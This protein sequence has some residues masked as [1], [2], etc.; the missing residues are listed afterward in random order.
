MAEGKVD[1]ITTK[2][3]EIASRYTRTQKTIY[4]FKRLLIFVAVFVLSYYAAGESFLLAL[5][6]KQ[7]AKASLGV[8][9]A[10][11]F[12]KF[13]FPK[14]ALQHELIEEQNLAVAVVAAAIILGVCLA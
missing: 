1:R 11:L 5:M 3:Q 9:L 10:I 6:A 12:I 13:G 7:G 4:W 14:A 2:A 8:V